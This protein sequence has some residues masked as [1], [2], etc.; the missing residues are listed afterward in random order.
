MDGT[1]DKPSLF[2][3][4]SFDF[5]IGNLTT[6]EVTFSACELCGFNLGTYEQ[7]IV[8]GLWV[9]MFLW[10]QENLW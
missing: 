5:F 3:N 6:E 8:T 7:K 10:F 1:R 9:V 2:L 4:T